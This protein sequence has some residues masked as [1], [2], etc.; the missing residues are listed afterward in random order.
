MKSLFYSIIKKPE[1]VSGPLT[2]HDSRL[3]TRIVS[4]FCLL[5]SFFFPSCQP[6]AVYTTINQ[7][8]SN[9][10]A[11]TSDSVRGAKSIQD[12]GCYYF[13]ALKGNLRYDQLA[14]FIPDSAD[15]VQIYKLT[16]SAIDGHY[17]KTLADTIYQEQQS[18][19]YYTVTEAK[20]VNGS[21]N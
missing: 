14:H 6:K 8:L 20:Q 5:T 19:F 11:N 9:F 21:W 1:I 17:I 10:V 12:L 2:T 15:I 4:I 3:T 16:N 7:P 18:S 13:L